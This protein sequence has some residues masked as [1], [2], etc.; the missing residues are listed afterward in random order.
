MT[1]KTRLID[2]ADI[3]STNSPV[4]FSWDFLTLKQDK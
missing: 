2:N 4:E 1:A 3:K